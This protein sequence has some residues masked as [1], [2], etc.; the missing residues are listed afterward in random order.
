M[1]LKDRTALVTGAATGIGEALA[2]LF[3]AE[4]AHVQLFDRDLSGCAAVAESIAAAG[5]SAAASAGDVRNPGEIMAAVR[6]A[7]DRFGRIDILINNAGIFP[8]RAFLEMSEAEWD[9]MQDVNLKSMFHTSKA[10]LPQMVSQHNGK[11]VN[12]S[13]VTFHLGVPG[14]THYVASKGGVIGLTRSLAR[15]MGPHNIHVNC[16]TPGAIH[17][18]SEANFVNDEQV[19]QFVASQSLQRRITPL[20]VARA[21]LFL[22]SELSDGMTGQTLNVDGGWAMH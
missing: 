13:S 21:C 1:L 16:V 11:I 18:R 7:M 12:V 22:S 2:R 8:R 10:V 20:D 17:T 19:R 5:G 6:S 14:L 15:E 4:G 9:E 3:A